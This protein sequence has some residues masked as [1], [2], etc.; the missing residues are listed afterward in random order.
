MRDNC[1][2]EGRFQ[3][4]DHVPHQ[5]RVERARSIV[6]IILQKTFGLRLGSQIQHF[7]PGNGVLRARSFL[8]RK[9]RPTTKNIFGRNTESALNE[10]GQ[11]GLPSWAE[12]KQGAMSKPIELPP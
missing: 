1:F 2:R 10:K 3:V 9:I 11:R 5:E 8:G 12:V 7:L 6:Q 4:V